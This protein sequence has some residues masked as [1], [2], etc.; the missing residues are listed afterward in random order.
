ML[1]PLTVLLGNIV[2]V[3]ISVLASNTFGVALGVLGVLYGCYM[4]YD[5]KRK[6]RRISRRLLC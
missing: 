4:L 5:F 1:V 6:Q 3:T 2:L